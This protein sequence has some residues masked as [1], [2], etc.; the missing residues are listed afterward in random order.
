MCVTVYGVE[1]A[2]KRENEQWHTRC[3]DVDS[4]FEPGNRS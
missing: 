4:F 3:V 2:F 1:S